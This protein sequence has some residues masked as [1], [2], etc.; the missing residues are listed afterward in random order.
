MLVQMFG[1]YGYKDPMHQVLL[2]VQPN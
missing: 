1:Q 2:Q